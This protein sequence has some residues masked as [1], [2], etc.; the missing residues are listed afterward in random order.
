[1]IGLATHP[2][3]TGMNRRFFAL[4]VLEMSTGMRR[5][6]LAGLRRDALD[7][8][9]RALVSFETRVAHWRVR[10]DGRVISWRAPTRLPSR[11]AI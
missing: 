3:P 6:E 4:W 10:V 11:A 2:V 1:M 9:Q 8:Y 7:R 5:C